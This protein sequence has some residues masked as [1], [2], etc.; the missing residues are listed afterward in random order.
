MSKN[1][2]DIVYKHHNSI[3]SQ[4]ERGYLNSVK[5]PFTYQN[6]NG[7]SITV[8][9]KEDYRI[10]YKMPWDIIKDTESNWSHSEL[11]QIEEVVRSN[12]SVVYKL[13]VRRI[14]KSGITDLI[15]QAIWISVCINREWGIQFRHNLG[16]PIEK[17][18]DQ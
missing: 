9:D 17:E 14:N 2:E 6:Y 12:S 13:L 18:I 11:E 16:A 7:V 8:K 5:F 4:D 10:N 15:I 1:T 3:N